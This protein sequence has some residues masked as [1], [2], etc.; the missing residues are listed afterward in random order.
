MGEWQD[1]LRKAGGRPAPQQQAPR[2][3]DDRGRATRTDCTGETYFEGDHLKAS[4]VARRTVEPIVVGFARDY[5][6]LKRNQLNRF[7]RYCRLIESRLQQ[8]PGSWQDERVN[9]LKLSAFA[10][11]AFGKEPKKIPESFRDFIDC[12]VDR[13]KDQKDFCDGFMEHFEA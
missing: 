5:P 7:F 3:F 12:N 2:R 13:I 4:Y 10:A 11:D 8:N 6:A 1:E 9:V